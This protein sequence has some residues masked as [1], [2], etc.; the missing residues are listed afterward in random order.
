MFLPSIQKFLNGTDE[1]IIAN[2]M[3]SLSCIAM[4]DNDVIEE[5]LDLE[6]T[7]RIIACAGWENLSVK[8]RALSVIGLLLSG[9]DEQ[10]MV[11]A[12]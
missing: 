3:W 2:V 11:T 8:L 10:T 4:G 1:G 5:I 7:D 12:C 6:C 9:R